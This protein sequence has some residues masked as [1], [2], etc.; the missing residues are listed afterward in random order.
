MKSLII[1]L[2]LI[3]VLGLGAG[4]TYAAFRNTQSSSGNTFQTG[5]LNLISTASGTGPTGKFVVTPGGDG[6]NGKVVFGG[7][8]V[9]LK[10]GES[11]KIIWTLTNTGSVSGTLTMAATIQS[12]ENSVTPPE[13]VAGDSGEP[14]ELNQYMG[15][16]LI[17]DGAYLVGNTGVYE[18][19]ADIFTT[20]N[21]QSRAMAPGATIV[22]ELNWNLA[23]DLKGTG[24]DLRFGTADDVQVNDNVIQSDILNL[25]I[26]FTLLQ[27]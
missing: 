26:T 4:S 1:S 25:N 13:A 22:Y 20:L 6:I 12:L 15:V 2:S 11:G 24:P 10:P 7:D 19:W 21:T 8:A 5:E 3:V 18:T 23:T 17:R 27:S 16:Q 14:G 9:K